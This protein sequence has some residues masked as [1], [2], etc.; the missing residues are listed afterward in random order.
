MATQTGRQKDMYIS[1]TAGQGHGDVLQDVGDGPIESGT[2]AVEWGEDSDD[3]D[4]LAELSKH[5]DITWGAR[6]LEIDPAQRTEYERNK[7]I[8]AVRYAWW[9][10]PD[11]GAMGV[12]TTRNIFIVGDDGKTIGKV[13]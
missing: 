4:I 7:G 10:V 2:V 13:R 1:I 8:I 3:N 6:L 5:L 12:A 9:Y 11:N